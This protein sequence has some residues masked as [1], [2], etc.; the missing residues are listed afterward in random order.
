MAQYPV[1]DHYYTI[2]S[3]NYILSGP[4]GLGQE[5]SGFS[6]SVPGYLTGNYREPF[7]LRTV[8]G[9]ADGSAG[10]TFVTMSTDTS[11]IKPGMTVTG[12]NITNPTTVTSVVAD[13]VNLSA[14]IL[15]DLS[16]TNLTFTQPQTP[17]LTVAPIALG[18][19]EMLDAYT[20]KFTF[21]APQAQPPFFNGQP[22]LVDGVTNSDYDGYYNPIGVVSCTTTYVIAKTVGAYPIVAPSTG[23]TVSLDSFDVL[24]STDCNAK[25]IVTSPQERVMLNAQLENLMNYSGSGPGIYYTVSLNRYKAEVTVNPFSDPQI[26]FFF[27]KTIAYRDYELLT[28]SVSETKETVFTGIVDQPGPGFYWYIVEIFLTRI[29]PIVAPTDVVDESILQLRSLSAQIVKP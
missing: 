29:G 4:T 23:G 13:V 22:I 27:D 3:L 17:M 6:S 9:Q 14:P 26:K 2:D 15:N 20:W 16:G 10:D 24:L 18:T 8:G 19:S 21:A 25:L 12:N 28:S 5:L 7:V 1:T 11:Q